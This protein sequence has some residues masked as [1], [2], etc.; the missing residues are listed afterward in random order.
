MVV[1]NC[2]AQQKGKGRIRALEF[3]LTKDSPYLF[4][5]ERKGPITARTAR[6]IV[7]R[8]G[9]RAELSFPVH[10][11]MLRH[12][13]GYYLGANS[14]DTRAVQAYLGHKNI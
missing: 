4:Q 10:P 9:D 1:V 11:H 8:A 2:Q 14:Q 5:T 6:N 12:A 13:T 7:A 3:P